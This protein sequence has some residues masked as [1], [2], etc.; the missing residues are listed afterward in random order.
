MCL[1]SLRP[2]YICNFH[3]ESTSVF[4]EC[5]FKIMSAAIWNIL[6]TIFFILQKN[7]CFS[8]KFSKTCR[9]AYFHEIRERQYCVALNNQKIYLIIAWV[10]HHNRDCSFQKFS[11]Q[12]QTFWELWISSACSVNGAKSEPIY[13]FF[14]LFFALRDDV[15]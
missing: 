11:H 1:L 10:N 3:A 7:I 12:S 14:R 5:V 6:N 4:S 8:Q 15:N 9:A 2:V 13:L